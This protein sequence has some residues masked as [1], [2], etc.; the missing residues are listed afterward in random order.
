LISNLIDALTVP[1]FNLLIFKR[2]G[3]FKVCISAKP[4]HSCKLVM[5]GAQ[6]N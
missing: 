3:W 1:S 5:L 6:L 4:L 2:K